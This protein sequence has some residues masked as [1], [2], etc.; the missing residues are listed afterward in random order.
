M[1]YF[2]I[3]ELKPY[4]DDLHEPIRCIKK[5]LK[6]SKNLTSIKLIDNIAFFVPQNLL[7]RT[8]SR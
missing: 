5:V 8:M 1:K 3:L 6:S 7:I 2:R 4:N